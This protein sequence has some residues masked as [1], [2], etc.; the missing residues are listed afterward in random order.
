MNFVT[1]IGHGTLRRGIIKNEMRNLT[2]KELGYVEKML[3]SSLRDGGIG[4][5]TGLIYTHARL[6]STEELIALAKI[7]RKFNGIYTT[8]IRNEREK[9]LEAVE[10]ALKIAEESG[11]KLH[12]SH[13]KVMEKENWSLFEAALTAIEKA[14]ER[15]VDVT[16][17]VFPYTNTGTVL[18]TLLPEWVSAGG[19]KML[20]NRLK[21]SSIRA[22][23]ISEMKESG[24]DYSKIEIALSSLNR[25]LSKRRI[26]DIAKSQEKSVEDAIVDVLIA[27]EGRVITSIESL[28]E[29]NIEKAVAHPLSIISTNGAGY[30]IEHSK[31]GEVVHP[32][33]FGTFPRII[34]QY[35]LGKRIISWEAAI[36][37]M[38]GIP[39]QKFGIKKRGEI[40]EKNFA[41][42][43]IINRDKLADLATAEN[44]YQYSKGVEFVLVNGEIILSE[45]VYGG[46][47]GG[48]IL[49]R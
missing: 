47:K 37:K 5:S 46:G 39:A 43:M 18:Y 20:I 49:I 38:T 35:V 3:D 36:R 28:S 44:P 15:G 11:V 16:F 12:I 9:F 31:T 24:F 21:E 17:D 27:S 30:S 6:A 4:M 8:H 23:V 32:R 2:P 22:K 34:S 40:K 48:R 19:K 7:V 41:D 1:L 14:Y 42:I 26:L 33:S 29:E 10:E 45:G 13:L 25:I